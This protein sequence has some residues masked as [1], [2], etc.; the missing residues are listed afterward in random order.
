MA[1]RKRRIRDVKRSRKSM[2]VRLVGRGEVSEC[3][4]RV[5]EGELKGR[6]C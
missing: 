5:E 3:S 2:V 6:S 1:Q 4:D